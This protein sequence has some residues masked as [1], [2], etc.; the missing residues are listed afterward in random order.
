MRGLPG[1]FL[2]P[3]FATNF[4]RMAFFSISSTVPPAFSI[5]SAQEQVKLRS[6]L[7][8]FRNE[9]YLVELFSKH[10]PSYAIFEFLQNI[11]VDTAE[12]EPSHFLGIVT[13]GRQIVDPPCR[14]KFHRCLRN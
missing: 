5:F 10:L 11:G 8:S 14:S 3:S 2:L 1:G 4:G 6:L 7:F 12:N 9:L 13:S